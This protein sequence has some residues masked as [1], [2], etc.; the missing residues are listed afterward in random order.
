MDQKELFKIGDRISYISKD[1]EGKVIGY[2]DDGFAKIDFGDFGIVFFRK[3]ESYIK[4]IR[5]DENGKLL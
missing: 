4:V 5:K 2:T 1:W 3:P